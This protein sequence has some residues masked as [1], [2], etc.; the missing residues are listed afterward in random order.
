MG[1]RGEGGLGWG[2]EM[3]RIRT[4]SYLLGGIF[5][6]FITTHVVKIRLKSILRE[7]D[8]Y[9][10]SVLVNLFPLYDPISNQRHTRTSL[11]SSHG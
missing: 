5:F 9:I 11:T 3:R 10:K 6:L 8:R 1:W 7:V 2:E 4:L